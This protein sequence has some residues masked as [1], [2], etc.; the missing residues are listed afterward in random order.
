MH[1]IDSLPLR[2]FSRLWGR[3]NNEY[4]LP[5][6]L[7]EPCY[8]LYSWIFKCNLEEIENTDLKSYPNLGSFFY[9][10]LKPDVRPIEN[11][12]LVG[13]GHDF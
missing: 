12:A 9:R 4:D 11:A 6:W 7:R 3:V 5:V 8:K 10:S 2:A 13:S 1:L